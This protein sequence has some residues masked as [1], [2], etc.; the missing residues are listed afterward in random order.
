MQR[1]QCRD[2]Y[3]LHELFVVHNLD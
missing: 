3:D 2:L 1:L